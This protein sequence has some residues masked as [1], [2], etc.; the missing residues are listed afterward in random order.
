MSDRNQA[1]VH[2]D[3]TGYTKTIALEL[4]K[5]SVAAKDGKRQ[6]I[7]VGGRT[8][9]ANVMGLEK[10]VKELCTRTKDKQLVDRLFKSM[11][12]LHTFS[13]QLKILSA[14][15]AAGGD[16]DSDDQLVSVARSFGYAIS[17]LLSNVAEA[18][19]KNRRG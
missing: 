13:T 15:K 16:K 17:D 9:H 6:E 18:S 2:D 1:V 3:I 12:A 11:E 19:I 14:V 10:K 8:V 7:I 5:I 4:A